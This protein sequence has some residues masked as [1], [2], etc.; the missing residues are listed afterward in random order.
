MTTAT[1]VLTSA[2][3]S[4][5]AR[6]ASA[7]VIPDRVRREIDRIVDEDLSSPEVVRARLRLIYYWGTR[8]GHDFTT[9]NQTLALGQADL[10][11]VSQK[12]DSME[13]LPLH[14]GLCASL[15]EI[16]ERLDCSPG[17]VADAAI[18]A[19]VKY[20][21]FEGSEYDLPG[22]FGDFLELCGDERLEPMAACELN[23][24]QAELDRLAVELGVKVEAIQ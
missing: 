2:T 20:F 16:A 5:D 24:S 22:T 18:K 3:R 19:G 17:D 1:E 14:P 13:P 12:L 7:A 21:S 8:D 10:A 4:H 11:D 23:I 6:V 15:G 9:L